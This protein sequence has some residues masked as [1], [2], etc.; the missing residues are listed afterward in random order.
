M[1]PDALADRLEAISIGYAAREGIDRNDDRF[2][3][4]PQEELGESTQIQLAR[5]GRSKPRGFT[6]EQLD[7]KPADE[8]ADVLGHILLLARRQRVDLDA[9][10]RAKWLRREDPTPTP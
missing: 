5:S 1:E 8:C 9:A 3:L 4:K 2:L 6:S 10:L 7:A